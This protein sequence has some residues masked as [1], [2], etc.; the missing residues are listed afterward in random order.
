VVGGFVISS[1]KIAT[2][3]II[4]MISISFLSMVS[5]ETQDDVCEQCGMTLDFVGQ[6]RFRIVDQSGNTHVACCPVCALKLLKTYPSLNIT[7]FC[8]YRGPNYPIT[9]VATN[10]GKDVTVNPP[11]ALLIVGGSC[12]RNR[13]VYGP[14]AADALLSS[15]NNGTSIWLSPLMNDTV[16]KN[17]TR[18]SIGQ[19]AVMFSGVTP[20]STECEVCGMTVTA[21]SQSRYK[22]I[23]GEGN[24]H[25]VECFMCA[26]KLINQYETL[27]IETTC[28]WYGPG[29]DIVIESKQY[30]QEVTVSPSTAIF[31]RGGSCVTARAAFNQTAADNLVAYGFSSFTSP[32]QQYVLPPSTEAKLVS[33]AI[34]T[35]YAQPVDDTSSTLF[36]IFAVAAGI[37]VMAISILAFNRL[38]RVKNN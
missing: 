31:L 29:Y 13:I 4:L 5:T 21:D 19:A 16:A 28:D 12:S 11:T 25:Y 32:E 23:D 15:P 17:A 10:H 30:G 36:L 35:W 33:E 2:V 9:I 6:Y 18:L 14:E 22:V 20:D 7:T 37:G 24:R 27:R 8:D 26:L 34:K 3:F 38:K 1:A